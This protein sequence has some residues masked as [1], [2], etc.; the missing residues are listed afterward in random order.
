MM[1][2]QAD[3]G[4]RCSPPEEAL[5]LANALTSKLE[6]GADLGPEDRARLDSVIRT[7][8][9]VGKREDLISEGESP[10]V[11][12]LVLEGFACRYKIL[13]NGRRQIMAFLIPGDFCDFHVAI[14]G[15]M[16]HSIATLTPCSIVEISRETIA[17]LTDHHPQ[18][19]R[20]LWWSTLVDEAILRE[21]LV[22]MGQR[23]AERQVAHVLCELLV[24][25]QSVGRATDTSYELPL[26]QQEL[27]DAM[28][29]SVVHTNR[30][31]Q[32]LREEG[33]IVWTEGRL[34][35]PNVARMNGFAGFNPNY[36]HLT[37]RPNWGP[38]AA[39]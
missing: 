33:L 18:I 28:G 39:A 38:Q 20:A 22:G 25:L 9:K 35:I 26:T 5:S 12:Q 3:K 7:P 8:R 32:T 2:C 17:D 31:L 15:T 1:L 13:P 34:T 6:R 30:S 23:P 11:V 24:R 16:D 29:L 14:L 27:G 21:W 19:A 4:S 10:S 36:L 37:K